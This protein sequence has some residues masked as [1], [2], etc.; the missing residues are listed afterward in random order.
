MFTE[1]HSAF[2]E[3]LY[4]FGS[5]ILNVYFGVQRCFSYWICLFLDYTFLALLVSG[6]SPF[7]VL[8]F[9]FFFLQT[10]TF[11]KVREIQK[12]ALFCIVLWLIDGNMYSIDLEQLKG[13]HV[14][15]PF[16]QFQA[17]LHQTPQPRKKNNKHTLFTK[18]FLMF[19]SCVITL[20]SHHKNISK[21]NCLWQLCFVLLMWIAFMFT[22]AAIVGKVYM[23][24]VILQISIKPVCWKITIASKCYFFAPMFHTLYVFVCSFLTLKYYIRNRFSAAGYSHTNIVILSSATHLLFHHPSCSC[25][26]FLLKQTV[27]VNTLWYRAFSL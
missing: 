27:T 10:D 7:F 18:W 5:F 1:V 3:F 12:N 4:I 26:A 8:C 6:F 15:A 25:L 13:R 16:G 23:E 17:A 11:Y 19:D 9:F 14:H 2:G 20:N 21:P 24:L 22:W